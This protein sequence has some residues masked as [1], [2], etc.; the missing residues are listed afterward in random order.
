MKNVNFYL[1]ERKYIEWD[2]LPNDP[3]SAIFIQSASWELAY[4]GA[5]ES[6]GDCSVSGNRIGALVSP[7]QSGTYILSVTVVIPPETFIEQVRITICE[8][9]E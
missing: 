5:A 7:L 9:E 4:N 3:K 1:G 6:F 8:S 2:I